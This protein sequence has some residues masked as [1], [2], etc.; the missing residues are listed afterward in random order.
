[1][2]VLIVFCH[3][4]KTSFNYNLFESIYKS[5]AENGHEIETSDLYSMGFDPALSSE[6]IYDNK[7]PQMIKE[8]QRK[9]QDSEVIFI[10]FP[11]WWWL[12]PAMLK[13]WLERVFI[14]DFAFSYS[15]EEYR[16]IGTLEAEKL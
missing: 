6:E 15:R 3:P 4:S 8:E 11:V 12:P 10:I 9:V 2:K 13:G 1:M 7:S 14:K 5:L 16:N